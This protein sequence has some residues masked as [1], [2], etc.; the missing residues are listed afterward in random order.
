V[1]VGTGSK[2]YAFLCADVRAAG[3][4]DSTATVFA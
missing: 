2:S 4:A 3:P 1:L